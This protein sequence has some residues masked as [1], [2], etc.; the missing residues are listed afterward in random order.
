[1]SKPTSSVFSL[2]A[3]AA[4][5][6]AF[7]ATTAGAAPGC[8]APEEEDADSEDAAISAPGGKLGPSLFR[9]DFFTY[10]KQDGHYSDEQI[11]QLILMPTAESLKPRGS[12]QAYDAA[13][14]K[15]RPTDF[16]QQGLITPLSGRVGPTGGLETELRRN[17][18]HIVIV[19]GIFGEFIPVSPF[20]EVFR[21][22]G[23]ASV[24][25][26][27]KMK[28]LEGDK[29]K[30]DLTHDRQ[31]SAAQVKDVSRSL[32]DL[33]RVGSI[34]D[35]DGMP[36]V[37]VTYLKPELGSLE[38]FGTL[39]ENADYYLSRLQKYFQVAGTPEHIYVM[40]YSRGTPTALNLVSR[41]SAA[42][43]PWMPKLRGVIALAGVIYGTPLADAA[44]AP[45]S[46]QRKLLDTMTDFVDNDLESCTEKTPGALLLARNLGHWLA[47]L[48]REALAA[49]NMPSEN[50]NLT[51][52]G[53]E[54]SF[55]DAGRIVSFARRVLLG[56]PQKVF[57]GGDSDSSAMLG[58]L[59]MASPNAE[60]CQNIERFKKTATQV[61]KGVQTLT[62][63]SRTDWFKTHTLPSNIRYFA[64]T[65]TM[66]DA[67]AEGTPVSPLALNET[68]YDTK[69]LDFRSLRGNY[70]DLFGASQH[71]LQDSQVPVHRAR[72]WSDVHTSMNP[73][74]APLD[75]YFMGTLGIHHWGLSFPRA[76]STK[77]GLTANPFPRTIL[78]K[79]IGT[80]VAQVE[81]RNGAR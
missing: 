44:L 31:F 2:L 22:G 3:K 29:S 28:A 33:V 25:W 17:P 6:A 78:L 42:K 41:A 61:I 51:R 30:N 21:F 11:K 34:D 71:Q 69:S 1:M 23:A 65:G 43:A 54:T 75:T 4:L 24:N 18:V 8:A 37:T 60:Y 12:M 26:D 58:V 79:S 39:D 66:G 50:E 73:K 27:R 7:V 16:Y 48:G 32:R 63:A 62:T 45:G 35:T 13:Y 77:D 81:S 14:A 19:P 36:L 64:I 57:A 67:T 56:D 9:N 38:T 40:G 47:F 52:E 15:I 10:L 68:A 76:F 55:A 46:A 53:I 59:H 72:F 5:A 49:R 80:F 74:Q 20:E 70:Y